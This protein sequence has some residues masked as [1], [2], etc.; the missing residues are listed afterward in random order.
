MGPPDLGVKFGDFSN[1]L[2][3]EGC[4]WHLPP[5]VGHFT[6]FWAK[7][8][9]I[10]TVSPCGPRGITSRRV[11]YYHVKPLWH[12]NTVRSAWSHHAGRMV[13][14]CGGCFH[15]QNSQKNIFSMV[16][17]RFPTVIGCRIT[18]AAKSARKF[19]PKI[20]L[21]PKILTKKPK[22]QL[23]LKKIQL[24]VVKRFICGHS[25]HI[26]IQYLFSTTFICIGSHSGL[27]QYLGVWW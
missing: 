11:R 21:V 16:F 14:P 1:G 19:G 18:F 27:Y 2:G 12:G 20:T 10:D 15:D 24:F 8:Y 26:Q 23:F 22:I 17:W 7:I 3:L 6:I 25:V 5:K 4:R 13:W 9:P